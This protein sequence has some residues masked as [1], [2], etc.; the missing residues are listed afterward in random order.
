M[1]TIA[2]LQITDSRYQILVGE[3]DNSFHSWYHDSGDVYKLEMDKIDY[4]LLKFKIKI[5]IEHAQ[6]ELRKTIDYWYIVYDVDSVKIKLIEKIPFLDYY[7]TK[8]SLNAIK[9][10]IKE[11]TKATKNEIV[12]GNAPIR[13]FWTEKNEEVK[14]LT[15]PHLGKQVRKLNVD[16]LVYRSPINKLNMMKKFATDCDIEVKEYIP[17]FFCYSRIL[18]KII[19]QNYV[20]IV[21]INYDKIKI[22]IYYG[23]ILIHYKNFNF[24]ASMLISY[25][26]KKFYINSDL[27]V[28]NLIRDHF[29]FSKI[30]NQESEINTSQSKI[31]GK[32]LELTRGK[33]RKYGRKIFYYLHSEINNYIKT[34]TTYMLGKENIPVFTTFSVVKTNG[35]QNFLDKHFPNMKHMEVTRIENED[36]SILVLLGMMEHMKAHLAQSYEN[37]NCVSNQSYGIFSRLGTRI[38]KH[39]DKISKMIMG[40]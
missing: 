36:N 15:P 19:D 10:V 2:T 29:S 28:T 31:D 23:D 39:T 37:I 32:I 25:I 11:R 40:G 21:D 3:L 4:S 14:S 8:S 20:A 16:A 34:V 30:G 1:N 35:Y 26:K 13:Y 27:K 18:P 22:M 6:R 38:S 17:S 5:A 12:I 24:G 33:L 7:S 9:K